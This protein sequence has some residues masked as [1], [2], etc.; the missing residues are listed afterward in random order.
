MDYFKSFSHSVTSYL[1]LIWNQFQKAWQQ[2]KHTSKMFFVSLFPR[3]PMILPC[4][5]RVGR[6]YILLNLMM[7]SGWILYDFLYRYLIRLVWTFWYS[8]ERLSRLQI[9]ILLILFFILSMTPFLIEF[10]WELESCQSDSCIQNL[11]KR[12]RYVQLPPQL[13]HWTYN[14][15]V[16]Q[17]VQSQLVTYLEERFS[18]CPNGLFQWCTTLCSGPALTIKKMSPSNWYEILTHQNCIDS[19]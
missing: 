17:L 5:G 12:R 3:S 10:F 14:K 1:E 15:T 7:S 8:I 6:V 18:S 11:L 4:Y 13:C 2:Q 16:E 9:S 19:K